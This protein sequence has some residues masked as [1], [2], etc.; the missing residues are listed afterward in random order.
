MCSTIAARLAVIGQSI[1]EVAGALRGDSPSEAEL[2]DLA[3]RL[4]RIWE[5]ITELDP[6]L[7]GRLP[8]YTPEA[9]QVQ[10]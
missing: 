6:A 3:G 8:A 1:D 4:A 5:M 7:A 9:A 2:D 10:P